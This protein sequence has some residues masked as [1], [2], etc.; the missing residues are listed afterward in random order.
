MK[1]VYELMKKTL[2]RFLCA[3]LVVAMVCAMAPAALAAVTP[4][5]T[6]LIPGETAS[7]TADVNVD[8]SGDSKAVTWSSGSESVATVDAT[9][10]QITAVSAGSAV[11]TA[12]S[13]LTNTV[14][15][16]TTITVVN[17]P[18][19]YTGIP[20]NKSVA[21]NAATK[22]NIIDS[23]GTSITANFT[24][25]ATTKAYPVTWDSTDY[26]ATKAGTYT[27]TA[28]VNPPTGF[29]TSLTAP[30]VTVTVANVPTVS[31]AL[32]GGD[33]HVTKHATDKV[34]LTATPTVTVLNSTG[35]TTLSGTAV[36]LHYQWQQSTNNSTF[37]NISGAADSATYSASRAATGKVYYKCIVTATDTTTQLSNSGTSASTF[38]DTQEAY[39]ITLSVASGDSEVNVG[40]T[41]SVTA[42]VQ[43]FD[44]TSTSTTYGQYVD[45]KAA[46]TITWAD[47][48]SDKIGYF[49]SST[50]TIS[51][52]TAYSSKYYNTF[53]TGTSST[54]TAE[55]TASVKI[56]DVTYTTATPLSIKIDSVANK[57]I[58]YKYAGTGVTVSEADFYD[59]L[60]TA[61]GS[62]YSNVGISNFYVVF[63]TQRGGTLYAIPAAPTPPTRSVPA[64]TIATIILQHQ[65]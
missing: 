34:T 50:S 36:T 24:G 49:S 22:Q 27:F 61:L 8:N 21:L 12:T 28:T 51:T 32:S 58:V 46:A 10:G 18:S 13:T 25:T 65:Q 38:V 41:P 45:Y 11:I 55:I 15:N 19:S 26:D 5:K 16:S 29:T 59:V 7:A 20:A 43:A 44:T 2:S 31:V 57:D 23:L 48:V 56:S 54:V 30:T 17:T 1:E 64:A 62:Y 63:G 35:T 60:K 14:S 37:T 6:T 42:H 40:E 53:S 33:V 52:S 3:L 9:T 4:D 39:Q 47:N